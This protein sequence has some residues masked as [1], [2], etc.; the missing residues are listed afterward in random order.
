[1]IWSL[2]LILFILNFLITFKL[3][4]I[5][6]LVNVFDKPDNYLKKHKS[7][8]PLLGGI[9]FLFNLLFV[10]LFYSLFFSDH[11]IIDVPI[12]HIFSI[13]IFIISFFLI[14]LID[15]KHK[16]KPENKLLTSIFFSLLI[17]FL[18]DDLLIL[19]ISLSFLE[20][21]VFLGNFGYF[22]TIFSIIILT[23]ALNFYDGIN[24]QSSLFFIIAF[25]YLA[26]KSPIYEFYLI[27]L[28]LLLFILCL[29]L[30][31]KIFMGDNGIYLLG[32]IL[33]ISLIYE[34]NKFYTFKFADEIFLL[35]ILP[36]YDLL[37]LSIIR[38]FN[39]RNLFYGDR[40]HIHH[41]LISKF[42]LLKTNII[43]VLLSALPIFL[44]SFF[45]INFYIVFS[46]FTISYILLILKL[47]KNDKKRYFRKK[48]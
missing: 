37:R 35:L 36:G 28:L 31:N 45:M 19:N 29:N 14:G 39:G 48:K 32:A 20:H 2:I 5:A 16:L 18:N 9:I 42:S 41:I 44:Y 43:L 12:R 8:V 6:F 15:D 10:V 23:N 38:L 4:Q 11:F 34:Y 13:T 7:N 27:V 33:S 46:L 25:S 40:N 1:M 17:L 26:L 24:G 22:F 47:S 30:F 3:K 21:P